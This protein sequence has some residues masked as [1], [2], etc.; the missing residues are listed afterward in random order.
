[1]TR[2]EAAEIVRTKWADN[3]GCRSCGGKYYSLRDIE[4][5]E[6]SIDDKDLGNGYVDFPCSGDDGT[7]IHRGTRIYFQVTR[8]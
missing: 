4:P 1:M 6:E 7:E 8:V 5:I 2:A 3:D